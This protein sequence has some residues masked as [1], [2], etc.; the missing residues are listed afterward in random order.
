MNE[1][2]TRD[3]EG[4]GS[5]VPNRM[6]TEKGSAVNQTT[7]GGLAEVPALEQ[8]AVWSEGV[9]PWVSGRRE[10]RV[11]GGDGQCRGPEAGVAGQL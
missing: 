7:G 2:D 3:E 10:L 6:G 1:M 5:Y 8:S 11:W 4:D 9:N